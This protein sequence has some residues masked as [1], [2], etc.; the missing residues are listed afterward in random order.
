MNNLKTFAIIT[1]FGF[2]YSIAS[3]KALIYREFK[4]ANIIDIDHSI[5]KFSIISAAFIINSVY[6]YFPKGTIFICVID[7]GVGTKRDIIYLNIDG[8]HFIGPN[9]GIFHYIIKNSSSFKVKKINESSFLSPS[10]T[11]HGRDIMTPAAIEFSRKNYSIFTDIE[12]SE[13]KFINAL[14]DN[15][16]IIIYSDNFGNIKT[17]IS[18]IKKKFRL[19]SELKITI[20]DRVFSA[21]FLNTF[22]DVDPGKLICYEGSNE[23]LEIAVNLGSAKDFLSANIGDKIS[24]ELK[25]KQ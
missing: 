10:N 23:T 20:N 18:S 13:V 14:E 15:L 6:R 25:N 5:E 12:K 8:Y 22:S 9:N 4:R 1:D 2:D 16:S 17:N 19:L 7:P 11:F 21:I 3:M 24:I